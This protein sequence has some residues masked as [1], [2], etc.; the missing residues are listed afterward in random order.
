MLEMKTCQD[1]EQ[2]IRLHLTLYIYRQEMKK[3]IY[4]DTVV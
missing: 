4:T 3:L 1:G 2:E